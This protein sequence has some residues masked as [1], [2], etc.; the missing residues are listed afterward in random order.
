MSS[1]VP[2][3]YSDGEAFVFPRLIAMFH[4]VQRGA[5]AAF[6]DAIVISE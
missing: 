6:I 1:L 5:F 4:T 2:A 3:I